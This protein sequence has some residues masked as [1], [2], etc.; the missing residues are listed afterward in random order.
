MK[1]LREMDKDPDIR[2]NFLKDSTKLTDPAYCEV[3]LDQYKVSFKNVEKKRTIHFEKP[4][5]L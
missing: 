5:N 4:R 1:N 3:T 2:D